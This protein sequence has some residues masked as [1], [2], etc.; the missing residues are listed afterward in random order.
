M[1][2]HF[3]I[4]GAVLP[5]RGDTLQI[6]PTR[7]LHFL[8]RSDGGE[9]WDKDSV[10]RRSRDPLGMGVSVTQDRIGSGKLQRLAL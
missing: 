8:G 1:E 2:G 7:H 6:S 10:P 3:G 4:S 5:P 9:V